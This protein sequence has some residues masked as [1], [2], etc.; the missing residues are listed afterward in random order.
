VIKGIRPSLAQAGYIKIGELSGQERVA[1]SGRKWRPPVKL[2]HFKVTKTTRGD[3]G[4]LEVDTSVMDAL[5]FDFADSDGLVRTVPIILHSDNID[6]VFPTQYAAYAGKQVVCRGNGEK[7][8]RWRY[9]DKVRTGKTFDH[10]CPCPWLERNDNGVQLCKPHGA[11]HCM[12]ALPGHAVAGAVYRYRTA[13]IISVQRIIGSLEQ[14]MALVGTISN[15]PLMLR[16]QPVQ[17]SPEGQSQT[18][19]A[20]H[21]ELRA[22]DIVEVQR[23]AI[24]ARETR[25]RL[26]GGTDVQIRALIQPPAS[27]DES[28]EEQEEVANEFH[29]SPPDDDQPSKRTDA[30]KQAAQNTAGKKRRGRPPKNPQP[31]PENASPPAASPEEAQQALEETK[32]AHHGQAEIGP[33]EPPAQTDDDN[34]DYGEPDEE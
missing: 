14:I 25:S 23:R 8:T 22:S 18:V 7:A 28:P 4:N 11:L 20:V 32:E 15:I 31:E 30:V 10:P 34:P 17:V 1:K 27:D 2:D 33:D 24:E 16:V 21:V 13:G 26:G 9:R 6:D 19:Y 12:L 5:Q 3:D 29:P